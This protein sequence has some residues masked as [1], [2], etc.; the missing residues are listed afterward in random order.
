MRVM[1]DIA[2][3]MGFDAE[4]RETLVHLVR[5]HL[6]L[7]ETAT[8]RDLSDPATI[9]RVADRVG[10]VEHLD[11]LAAL[12]RADSLATGHTSWTAW[13]KTL[14][15]ELVIRTRAYF[16]GERYQATFPV[17]TDAQRELMAEQTLRVATEGGRL[18]VVAI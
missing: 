13:K 6:F 16:S 18:T 1:G 9:E 8:Q 10:S 4:D 14:L 5:D 11:L 7:A 12:T 17:P 2:E 3:R 15:E